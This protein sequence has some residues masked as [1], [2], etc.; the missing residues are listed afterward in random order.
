MYNPRI[1]PAYD[2]A[3]RERIDCDVP[4]PSGCGDTGYLE[5]LKTRLPGF[6]DGVSTTRPRLAIY[7]AG[8]DI[9]EHDFLG[10][11]SVSAEGII[12]RD[13][14]VIDELSRRG[15]PC[16][17]VLSGGYH[18]ESYRIIAESIG[19]LIEPRE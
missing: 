15:I 14:F 5:L 4:L 11:L 16:A 6:L 17:M 12:E 9:Y 8:T 2:T 19:R 1:Y 18:R 13:R 10:G 7:N 3:A